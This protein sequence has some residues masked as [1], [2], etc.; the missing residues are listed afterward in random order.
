[1]ALSSATKHAAS[2]FQRAKNTAR[3]PNGSLRQRL[4]LKLVR[5]GQ[6]SWRE[7][8][9]GHS[10]AQQP[11]RS[12]YSNNDKNTL[13]LLHMRGGTANMLP[14]ARAQ[15]GC[16]LR[17]RSSRQCEGCHSCKCL[18]LKTALTKV[19]YTAGL[20]EHDR[21]TPLHNLASHSPEGHPN[22]DSSPHECCKVYGS[23]IYKAYQNFG[24][25]SLYWWESPAFVL[26]ISVG[27]T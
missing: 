6:R 12:I 26:R 25:M 2:G 15:D 24:Y 16:I 10:T 19:L 11:A 1:M 7:T 4:S 18:H 23:E 8:H 3:C 9:V 5:D 20:I 14:T 17:R 22:G 13:P 27:G 21:P